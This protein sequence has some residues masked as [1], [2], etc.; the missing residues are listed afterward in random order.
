MSVLAADQTLTAIQS[1]MQAH[2]LVGDQAA[3]ADVSQG[4]GLSPVRRLGI[5][6]HAYRARLIET[7]GDSFGHTLSYLGD[8]WFEHLAGLFI[9]AHPSARSN[10]RW[11]GQA[12][13]DWLDEVLVDGSSLGAHPEVAELARLDWALRRAFDAA[14][15]TVLTLADLAA[16]TPDDWGSAVLTAQPSASF[17]SLHCNTLTL[18]HALDQDDP[19]PAAALLSEPVGVLVWRRDDSP[20]F[21]SVSAMEAV[22]VTGLL[23]GQSFADICA[24]LA[25]AFPAEDTTPVA[26]G[27][28]RR[29]VDE[30][31]LAK[32]A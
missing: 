22:A 19:V 10:L 12:W 31:L 24:A 4:Q 23:A 21:R 30:G 2:V 28:L 11:Y 3:L 32:A 1:R 7:L 14:N 16:M 20:H 18:W 29:W 27:L 26:G 6:H 25:E 17:L 8:E 15:A 13:P 9:E 5:Y